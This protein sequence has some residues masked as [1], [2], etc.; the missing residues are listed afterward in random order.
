M[1]IKGGTFYV[2]NNKGEESTISSTNNINGI[3]LYS[4]N[5]KNLNYS[6]ENLNQFTLK[7]DLSALDKQY[8]AENDVVE[9]GE[10]KG[11]VIS[12][13]GPSL[14]IK[15]L[16]T[17]E[18]ELISK[19]EVSKHYINNSE[20]SKLIND[21][22]NNSKTLIGTNPSS[23]GEYL[24]SEFNWIQFNDD[25]ILQRGD[26]IINNKEV[27]V[28]TDRIKTLDKESVRV[29]TGNTYIH[30]DPKLLK[31][32]W[33]ATDRNQDVE[34]ASTIISKNDWYV[35]KSSNMLSSRPWF[36]DWR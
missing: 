35:S 20:N 36:L 34:L 3:K 18:V 21:L 12:I 15:N 25:V 1:N 10:N 17:N 4:S 31:D 27:W 16:V 29:F 19:T 32:A 28:V 13:T 5:H 26:Y 8:I 30:I 11:I 6:G 2:R 14:Y 7:E 22:S 33:I 9:F 24:N 23:Y